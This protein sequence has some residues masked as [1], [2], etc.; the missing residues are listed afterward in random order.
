MSTDSGFHDPSHAHGIADSPLTSGMVRGYVA[1]VLLL[2]PP[3]IYIYGKEW[4]P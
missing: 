2:T 3:P 1:Q 4:T